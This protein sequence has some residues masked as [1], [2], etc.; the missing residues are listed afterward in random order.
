MFFAKTSSASEW[1]AV[2]SAVKTL[3]EEATFEATNENLIFRAMDPSHIALVDLNWPNTFAWLTEVLSF[4][5]AF[6]NMDGLTAG[7]RLPRIG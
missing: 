1:K 2:A 6:E 3:V 7:Y 5:K 4:D